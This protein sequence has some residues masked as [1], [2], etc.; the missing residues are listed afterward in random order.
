MTREGKI[1]YMNHISKTTTW[2]KPRLQ[3]KRPQPVPT[4]V[5]P[6]PVEQVRERG[7]EGWRE[8][9]GEGGRDGEREGDG[10]VGEGVLTVC[11]VSPGLLPP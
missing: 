4:A 9:G 6:T 2:E 10:R 1:Y 5:Q 8:R 3:E 7:G 11:G